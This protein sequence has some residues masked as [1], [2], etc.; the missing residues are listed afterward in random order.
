MIRRFLCK[1][2]FLILLIRH[3]SAKLIQ[4]KYRCHVATLN[5]RAIAD[6]YNSNDGAQFK[7]IFSNFKENFEEIFSS[8]RIHL[9][10]VPSTSSSNFASQ[11][12]SNHY[13]CRLLS[14]LGSLTDV[15]ES[16][17][18]KVGLTF[19]S[20][21]DLDDYTQ[22]QWSFIL[23]IGRNK[24]AHR[25]RFLTP[26]LIRKVAPLIATSSAALIDT[27][28]MSKLRDHLRLVTSSGVLIPSF[29]GASVDLWRMALRHGL[30]VLGPLPSTCSIYSSRSGNRR[31]FQLAGISILPG[32]TNVLDSGDAVQELIEISWNNPNY[33]D[34][35]ITCDDVSLGP[36][37]AICSIK[38]DKE[39]EAMRVGNTHGDSVEF[40]VYEEHF[41]LV[42]KKLLSVIYPRY[43]KN[44]DIFSTSSIQ[45]FF[46]LFDST[47]GVVEAIPDNIAGYPRVS[48]LI[49][50]SDTSVITTYDMI[51]AWFGHFVTAISPQSSTLN[52]VLI[53]AAL[54]IG[55]AA[56][57]KGIIG[58]VDVQFV[59]TIVKGMPYIFGY[60][61]EIGHSVWLSNWK[62]FDCLSRGI[63]DAESGT[64][65]VSVGQNQF[66]LISQRCFVFT[67]PLYHPNL[68][69][70]GDLMS[71][72]KKVKEFSLNLKDNPKRAAIPS[73]HVERRIGSLFLP[74]AALSRGFLSCGHVA[75][76]ADEA[77][78][79]LKSITEFVTTDLNVYSG[80]VMSPDLPNVFNYCD[81]K[82]ALK[83]YESR[84]KFVFRV[85]IRDPGE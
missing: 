51:P 24:S 37:T 32:V 25:A 70:T 11:L 79:V 76:T 84:K 5:A 56:R 7:Q 8:K 10:H 80:V 63:F 44:D 74:C 69:L 42:F 82:T 20:H 27:K 60:S 31:I 75:V 48:L 40:H 36:I 49:T 19:L 81:L 14:Y 71:L 57:E 68:S 61:L 22:T 64:Y 77:L 83:D 2:D 45:D 67:C 62:A 85:E 47:G 72:T 15:R 17:N 6:E 29:P 50:P 3:Q 65:T 41:K 53:G 9:V 26:Q 21:Y 16:N 38:S 39:L 52:A 23:S 55:K 12:Q 54:E 59:S 4:R 28:F 35:A 43:F 1:R 78:A 34:W 18:Q 66:D 33:T 73:F 13:Q 30:H 58:F 46:S